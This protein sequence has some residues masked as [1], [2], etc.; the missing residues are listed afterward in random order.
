MDILKFRTYAMQANIWNAHS[1]APYKFMSLLPLLVCSKISFPLS[2]FFLYVKFSPYHLY[3]YFSPLMSNSPPLLSFHHLST[4]LSPHVL[5]FLSFLPLSLISLFLSLLS[6]CTISP[7]LSSIT[8]KGRL[9]DLVW[10][11]WIDETL[12]ANPLL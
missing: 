7:P 3:L 11:W 2:Y 12:G 9:K 6:L 5:I 1:N 10:F 8:K 4:L